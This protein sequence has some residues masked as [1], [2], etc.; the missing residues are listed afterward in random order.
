MNGRAPIY[1]LEMADAYSEIK[2][3]MKQ[4]NL[5]LDIPVDQFEDWF[6]ELSDSSRKSQKDNNSF[7]R[8]ITV[9]NNGNFVELVRRC[10]QRGMHIGLPV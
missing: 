6:I 3:H 10:Q 8:L 4:K 7:E 2:H 1:N 5:V 9:Q